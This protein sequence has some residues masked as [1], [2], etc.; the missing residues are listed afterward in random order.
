MSPIAD[1]MEASSSREGRQ[2]ADL[3]TLDADSCHATRP[4]TCHERL[5]RYLPAK[6]LGPL[7]RSSARVV[8]RK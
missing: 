3:S 1:L 6:S 8:A 4:P 7:E 5:S 2:P